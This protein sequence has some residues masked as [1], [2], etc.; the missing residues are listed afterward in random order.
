[1]HKDQKT[2]ASLRAEGEMHSTDPLR[3]DAQPM[4]AAK[5]CQKAVNIFLVDLNHCLFWVGPE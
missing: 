4:W 3:G 1:M 2:R 5:I